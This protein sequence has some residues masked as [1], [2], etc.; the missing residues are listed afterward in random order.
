MNAHFTNQS[1]N[2]IHSFLLSSVIHRWPWEAYYT[3]G[4]KEVFSGEAQVSQETPYNKVLAEQ[5]II[6]FVLQSSSFEVKT[7]L[8]VIL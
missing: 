8:V 2:S 7:I 6:V 3:S 5:R 4:N 1:F